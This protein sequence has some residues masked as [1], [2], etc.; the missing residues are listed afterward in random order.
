MTDRAVV[1]SGAA[2]RMGRALCP[3]L[4]AADGISLVAQIDHGDSIVDTVARRGLRPGLTRMSERRSDVSSETSLAAR[5]RN[6]SI[7]S[8]Y[9]QMKGTALALSL[10]WRSAS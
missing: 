6:G 5:C 9:F 4:A 10:T 3:G 7:S 8:R 1:F 2:G